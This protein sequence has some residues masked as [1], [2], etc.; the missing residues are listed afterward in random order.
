MGDG[1]RV[2]RSSK[3]HNRE[4][5]LR[6]EISSLLDRLQHHRRRRAVRHS[7]LEDQRLETHPAGKI[8]IHRSLVEL[9]HASSAG[10][11]G[12]RLPHVTLCRRTQEEVRKSET[13]IDYALAN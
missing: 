2:H 12:R 4:L 7:E 1:R 9:N 6:L 8:A 3:A 5:V 10:M 11:E 13:S